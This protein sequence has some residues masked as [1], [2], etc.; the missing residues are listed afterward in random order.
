MSL[1]SLTESSLQFSDV[2]IEASAS[3]EEKKKMAES[4]VDLLWGK[5]DWDFL[6][7]AN[8]TLQQD[9][10]NHYQDYY[11]PDSY[12][13]QSSLGVARSSCSKHFD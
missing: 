1:S 6:L 3:S 12:L 4:K 7:K 9:V 2:V 11:D 8:R 13:E 10:E 5:K